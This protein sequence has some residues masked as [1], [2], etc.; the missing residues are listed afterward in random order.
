[1]LML[2]SLFISLY[3]EQCLHGDSSPRLDFELFIIFDFELIVG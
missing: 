2:L 1:L 3:E